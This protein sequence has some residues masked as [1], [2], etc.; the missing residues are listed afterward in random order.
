MLLIDQR[1]VRAIAEKRLIQLAY[2][3][4]PARIVEPHDYGLQHGTPYLL[5]YQLGGYSRSASPHGWRRFDL[6]HTSDVQ[7]LDETFPG[8]RNDESQ[9]HRKWDQLFARV[10]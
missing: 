10:L 4:S 3:G 2:R 7:V 8:S 1:L 5:A 6:T 9:Q